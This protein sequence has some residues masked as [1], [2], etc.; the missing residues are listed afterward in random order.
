MTSR[1]KSLS[2][3]RLAAA[4]P[5]SL[6]SRWP[7]IPQ[8]APSHPAFLTYAM[9]SSCKA[10][11]NPDKKSLIAA[12]LPAYRNDLVRAAIAVICTELA[13]SDPGHGPIHFALSK[14]S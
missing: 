11:P 4:T 5:P 3:P 8:V 6:P 1:T 2:P 7:T 12:M 9:L 14:L 10:E 13:L